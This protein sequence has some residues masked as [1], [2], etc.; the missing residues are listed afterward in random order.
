MDPG[1]SGEARNHHL[2]AQPQ[3]VPGQ[4][5]RSE[6]TLLIHAREIIEPA[7]GGQID[8]VILFFAR[9]VLDVPARIGDTKQ[10]S[11]GD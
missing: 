4:S 10:K 1:N 6:I 3:F 8:Q 7:F 2:H 5:Q 9:H 11:M